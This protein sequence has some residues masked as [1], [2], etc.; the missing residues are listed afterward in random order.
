MGILPEP[1]AA[2]VMPWTRRRS[3]SLMRVVA[4]T[5]ASS[6]EM[7]VWDAWGAQLCAV[8]RANS[9]ASKDKT[10]LCAVAA[11]SGASLRPYASSNSNRHAAASVRLPFLQTKR[12]LAWSRI[13]ASIATPS[14]VVSRQWRIL[15][16]QV[17]TQELAD[18]S[19]A[20]DCAL[21]PDV[22][23]GMDA[24]QRAPGSLQCFSTQM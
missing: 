18:S 22:A 1:W 5:M 19:M 10:T 21:Y 15:L 8:A 24:A 6:V 7:G 23:L 13:A 17:V 4:S 2:T 20:L 9:V 14:S 11:H 3:R 16:P 12:F